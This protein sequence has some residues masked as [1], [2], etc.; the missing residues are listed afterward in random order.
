M[1]KIT[2]L[3]GRFERFWHWNQGLLIF[4][5][6]LTGF[7]IHGF[8]NL[9]S[10]ENSVNWHNVAAWAFLVLIID[11]NDAWLRMYKYNN[12]EEVTGKHYSITRKKENLEELDKLIAKVLKGG[13]ITGVQT[14]RKCKDGSE[15]KHFLSANPVF[16]DG[17]IVGVEGFILD[18][19]ESRTN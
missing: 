13:S 19:P 4:F 5:L 10:F 18:N 12:K 1:K 15:E 9:F 6:A 17:E 8:Y 2:Y 14:L 11:A 3:Y 7:E 16:E